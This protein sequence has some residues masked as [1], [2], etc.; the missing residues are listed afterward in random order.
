MR[1]HGLLLIAT[2]TALGIW[3][4]PV[5]A[6][7]FNSGSTGADGAFG[8][9]CSPT[10]CTVTVP[11]SASGVFH[12]TTVNVPAGITVKYTRN[13]ANTPVTILA[14]GNV[15]IA[16]TID[17][18]GGAGGNGSSGTQLVPNAGPGGPGGFD[19]G[20]GSNGVIGGVSSNGGNGRGPGGGVGGWGSVQGG[21]GGGSYLTAG[22]QGTNSGGAAGAVYGTSTLAPL[23]GGSGGGGGA[24]YSQASPPYIYTGGGGGGGGGAVLIAS[25]T[26]AVASTITLSGTIR[27]KGGTGGTGSCSSVPSSSGGSG[28]GG[29]VRLVAQAL[30]GMGTIDVSGGPS[31][32]LLPAGGFGRVRIEAV[33][34]SA[35]LTL[36]GSPP[37]SVLSVIGQTLPPTLTNSPTL[38][39][40]SVGGVTAP[41]VPTGS[42]ANPD[43]V[44]PAGTSSV[45]VDFA[46]SNIPLGTTLTVRVQGLAN[47]IGSTTTTSSA[48]SGSVASSTATAT[49][50]IPTDQPSIISATAS[51]PLIAD[52]GRG[53]VYADG[54]PVDQIRLTAAFGRESELTYVTV[55]GREFGIAA[56]R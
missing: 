11:L 56:V 7:Y 35:T 47:G 24:G 45:T 20:S 8:P 9:S 19:G 54:E 48:L 34:N 30:A 13:A 41:T 28:S 27:A 3:V 33:S 38:T 5:N 55:S 17:V 37:T 14:T 4:A 52:A 31:G 2:M 21:G 36:A 49:V 51:F 53:P 42:F 50:T 40:T 12:Y 39:I 16:G 15:T 22:G 44:L 26:S 29:A 25:G 46:A 23:V 10:P 18:S 1:P 6:Q 43:V 32:C